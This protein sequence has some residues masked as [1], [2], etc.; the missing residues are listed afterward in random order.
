[1]AYHSTYSVHNCLHMQNLHKIAS[2]IAMA[3]VV[4]LAGV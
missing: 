2:S 3:V 4:D 1:M